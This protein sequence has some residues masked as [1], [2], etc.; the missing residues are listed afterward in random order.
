MGDSMLRQDLRQYLLKFV[1][2]HPKLTVDEGYI[3]SEATNRLQRQKRSQEKEMIDIIRA[4]RQ[5][6][7]QQHLSQDGWQLL[8][9]L[10][11]K[12]WIWG[13]VNTF[14]LFGH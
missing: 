7:Y 8:T 10:Q 5:L 1:V 9:K 11:R 6:S 2:K 12:Q 3:I 13:V 4:L 14:Q